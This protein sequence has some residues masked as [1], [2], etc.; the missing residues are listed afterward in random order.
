MFT[1]MLLKKDLDILTIE[2]VNS[3]CWKFQKKKKR[4]IN[5]LFKLKWSRKFQILCNHSQDSL[6]VPATQTITKIAKY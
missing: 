6:R 4:E 2:Y 5:R 3:G 1:N